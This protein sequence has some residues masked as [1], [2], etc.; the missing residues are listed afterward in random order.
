MKNVL[1]C[2]FV[3]VALSIG[4]A[5]AYNATDFSTDTK[6]IAAL[7]L[8]QQSGDYDVFTNM[9]KNAVK[10]KF[11]NLGMSNVYATNSYDS[12]GRRVILINSIYKNAPVEQ[13]ACL[14]AHESCHTARRATMEEETT[15][16]QK[17]ASCW[18]RLKRNVAY[19]ETKLTK[20][21]DKLADLY[22]ASDSDTNYIHEKIASST[23]YR[24]QFGM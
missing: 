15:A 9:Q 20:R 12:Y 16:T 8:L 22:L 4:Q 14:I 6:I 5:F 23:F 19:P 13:I 11:Y 3:F 10:I 21:L 24:T 1:I 18:T 7:N 2:V 17:E